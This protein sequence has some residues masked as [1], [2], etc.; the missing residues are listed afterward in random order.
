MGSVSLRSGCRQGAALGFV[1]C[2]AVIEGRDAKCLDF[3]PSYFQQQM[4][5]GTDAPA[6]RV[7]R[8]KTPDSNMSKSLQQTRSFLEQ[9]EDEDLRKA[10]STEI[11]PVWAQNRHRT[12]GF[13]M[14]FM[15][16]QRFPMFFLACRARRPLRP[17][18]KTSCGRQNYRI[19][20][21]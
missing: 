16:F 4:A 3:I 6:P 11:G 7:Q 21:S 14:D 9:R 13:D 8:T 17:V 10:P 15:D 12:P 20:R 19:C 5:H 1:G 2:E 18:W